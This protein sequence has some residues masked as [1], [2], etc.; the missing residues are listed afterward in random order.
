MSDNPTPY[1]QKI[2]LS[3]FPDQRQRFDFHRSAQ[4]T[5]HAVAGRFVRVDHAAGRG[6]R[7]EAANQEHG[8]THQLSEGILASFPPAIPA[9]AAHSSWPCA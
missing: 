7:P 3:Q 1:G 4:R 2:H 5:L 8:R 9:K 6:Y